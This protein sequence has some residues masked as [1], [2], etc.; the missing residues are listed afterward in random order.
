MRFAQEGYK[1]R[2]DKALGN[3]K[4][5]EELKKQFNIDPRPKGKGRI[6]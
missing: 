3:A 6:E 1:E 5:S 4:E 2:T